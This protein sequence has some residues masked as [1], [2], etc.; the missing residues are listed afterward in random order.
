MTRWP[1]KIESEYQSWILC[2]ELFH[3]SDFKYF[4]RFLWACIDDPKR[5]PDEVQFTTRLAYDRN[6]EPDEQGYSHPQVEKARNLFTGFPDILV[7]SP[8]KVRNHLKR[9]FF[10]RY[11]YG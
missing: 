2:R 11:G 6:L 10:Q 5:A 9:S 7:H 4:A 8:N 1:E 3:A